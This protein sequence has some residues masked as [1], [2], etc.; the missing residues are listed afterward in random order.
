MD[1]L[2]PVRSLITDRSVTLYWE[3]PEAFKKDDRYQIFLDGALSGDTDQ[4]HYELEELEA[5][6]EYR[7]RIRQTGTQ[8]AASDEFLLKTQKNKTRLDITKPPYNAV[9]DGK[10]M[11]TRAIQRA[12][13]DCTAQDVVYIPASVFL[14]GALRLHSDM[15]LYLA[16]DAVLQGTDRAEDYLPKI[17]SRFEGTELPCY[18]SL[19]NLGTLDRSGGYTCRNVAIR[20]KGTV[21]SGGKSLAKNVVAAE[22]ER[23]KKRLASLGD[24]I[25]EYEKP[26]TIPGRVRP[27]LINLSNC[28][29]VSISG[30][31]L[32]NGASWNFHM[33]YSDGIVTN[34]CTFHSEE[35]W[36]GDGWDP[37]S[38]S[39][40][41][42]FDCVFST[43]DDAISIKSGKN[44]EGNLIGRPCEHIRIFDCRSVFG[45]GITIGSEMSGG[46]RDVAIWDCDM[47][48]SLCGIEIKGTKK[49]GGYVRDVHVRD[50]RTS[51]IQFHSVGYNDDGV[52]AP[53]PPVFEKCTF[54]SVRVLGKCLGDRGEWIPC[55]AITICGFDEPGHEL[56][57]IVFRHI[58][59][60]DLGLD[61]R[62]AVSLQNCRAITFQDL[63]VQDSR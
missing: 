1:C 3:K 23:L 58:T 32:K 60:E 30:L 44:P 59:I 50:C 4:T 18:S 24:G 22:R 43:G 2:G 45:H 36:N 9:G 14:T 55:E 27:R 34:G 42:I 21:A 15:E 17:S 53:E 49:R 56:N 8:T 54:D 41:T 62:Q 47:G 39:N 63:S 7:V 6:R 19:L 31:T 48:E 16:P 25:A 40:C 51:R 61:G 10:S 37:D 20:G 33:I 28:Q 26:E 11:N 12:I 52:G 13:D 38:S 46:V 29:N 35:V 5:D 57:E